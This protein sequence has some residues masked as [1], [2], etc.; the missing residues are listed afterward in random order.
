KI[1]KA[2]ISRN[3]YDPAAPA[4]KALLTKKWL[5]NQALRSIGFKTTRIFT[6]L[7]VFIKACAARPPAEAMIELMTHP[8]SVHPSEEPSLLASDWTKRLSY[9]IAL[10][11]YKAL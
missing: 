4:S 3:L 10:M 11:S 1:N 6:D 8:G 7:D 2:R 9:D 5:Y